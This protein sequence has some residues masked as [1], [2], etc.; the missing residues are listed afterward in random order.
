MKVPKNNFC[1][2]YQVNVRSAERF[3]NM[4]R[5]S[6]C[7]N[8]T[9]SDPLCNQLLIPETP[10]NLLFLIPLFWSKFIQIFMAASIQTHYYV[11]QI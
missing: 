1:F 2:F 5:C 3:F 7:P 9:I 6:Y 10:V 4:R 11:R 8:H